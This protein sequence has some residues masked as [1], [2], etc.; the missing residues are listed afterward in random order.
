LEFNYVAALMRAA[1]ERWARREALVYGDQRWT[2]AQLR[3]TVYRFA[4]FLRTLSVRAGDGVVVLSGN[5]PELVALQLAVHLIGCRFALIALDQA[6]PAQEM[7]VRECRPA[8]LIFD[9][10][11]AAPVEALARVAAPR[12]LLSL[13]PA[14]LGRDLLAGARA[15]DDASHLGEAAAPTELV[16]TLLCTGGSTGSPKGVVHTHSL[17]DAMSA[18]VGEQGIVMPGERWLVC[19]KMTHMSGHFAVPTLM[20]GGTLIVHDEFDPGAVLRTV[21]AERITALLLISTMLNQILEHP[22][23]AETDC[24]TVQR[25]GYGAAP[26]PP[27]LLRQA[28]ARFG[29]VLQQIYGL[30]ETGVVSLLQPADHLSDRPQV[31]SCAGR[32]IPGVELEIRN[33]RGDQLPAGRVGEVWVRSP[34]MMAGYLGPPTLTQEVLD[35]GWLRTGDLG[36]LDPEG[37]LFLA[38]RMKEV[39]LHHSAGTHVYPR[40]I[41]DALVGHP[42]VRSAAVL[43]LPTNG[44]DSGE[45][46]HAVI[47]THDGHTADTTALRAHVRTTLG[48]DHMVPEAIDIVDELPLTPMGKVDKK[49]LKNALIAG[50]C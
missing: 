41:E 47:V 33:E 37:F 38:G 48:Q 13:G 7:F 40:I 44:S 17:Y 8:V 1:G 18:L 29:P 21:A 2:Y 31:L 45:R 25:I 43:G 14:S 12:H 34:G 24:S 42:S 15:Q 6:R 30:T 27:Q 39:I 28:L 4:A 16:R 50:K 36:S 3:E 46:V 22:D 10:G 35:D 5:R 49:T 26:T 23:L 19:T 9:P 32:A 20:S 11:C